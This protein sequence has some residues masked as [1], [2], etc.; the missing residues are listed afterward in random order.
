MNFFDRFLSFISPSVGARRARARALELALRKYEGA[1]QG[2]R[3]KNWR[4]SSSSANAEIEGSL[5]VL[6]DRSRQ[7]VRD[8]ATAA[9]AMQVITSNVVGWGIF[10]QIKVAPKQTNANGQNSSADK[11]AKEIS[12]VWKAWS[13]STACDFD[14][15]HD[16]CGLQRLIMRT[17]PEGGEVL[18]RLRR[19]GKRTVVQPDGRTIQLPPIALQILEG[20]FLPLDVSYSQ[21][22]AV[23]GNKIVQ[24]IELDSEGKRVAYHLYEEHPG[25]NIPLTDS[26]MG[27]TKTV[28]VPANEVLHIFRTDRAGQLR[29][30]PWLAP[31][32]I[33]LRDFDEFED[34]QLVRQK[35][36]AMFAVFIKDL[37]G[38][39]VLPT[40]EDEVE[41]G[42]KVEPG[43]VEFLPP[44]KDISFAS[45]PGVEGYRDY[46]SGQLHRIATGLGITYESVTGDLSQVNFSS[47]RMGFLEMNRNI[48]E[49]RE[50]IMIQQ[51]LSPVFQWFKEVAPLVGLEVSRALAFFTAPKRE[52]VNP[53]EEI[54]ALKSAV[55]AGFQ[56]LSGAIQEL[57][58]DPEEHFAQLKSDNDLL[59]KLGLV[60][61][62]DPRADADRI[63]PQAQPANPAPAPAQ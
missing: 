34:A 22:G 19:V 5:R 50:G 57:G 60:L 7:L 53:K 36:A 51:F 54:D 3:T 62:T 12:R 23:L 6:R 27:Q 4:A 43:I 41:I 44:G 59:D 31:V 61:D 56:T 45:P 32:M 16:L 29:G 58:Y 38:A 18:V 10:T 55:R 11:A 33:T 47:A 63:P 25:N 2:R 15:R 21:T 13:E 39:D 37:D 42:E 9:R 40:S 20:D 35:I 1:S 49:W 30:A 46:T 17:V 26:I 14:G 24:G 8:N 28:R 52:M 48:E